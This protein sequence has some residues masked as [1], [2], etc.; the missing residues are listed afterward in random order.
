MVLIT[1][2]SRG[3]GAATAIH[4]ASQAYSICISY[5]T[6]RAMAENLVAELAFLGSHAIAVQADI[7]REEDIL[8]LFKTVDEELGR[9]T[10]L[11]NN[12]GILLRQME[13]EMMTSDR[14]NQIFTTNVTGT[15]ICCR[16]A[17]KRMAI[18]N[19]GN[20]GAI[21]NV[22]SV[23]SRTGAAGEYVDYAASKGAMDTLTKG[24]S[25]EVAR[26]G[27]RV[28]CVRPGLIYT[29]IHSAG[30]EPDRIERVKPKIPMR[31]GGQPGE[32]AA[33]I[34]WLLSDGASYTTG[35]F[36]DLAGGI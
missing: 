7:S 21:V 5:K 11:V 24:L 3:I 6:N 9:L 34:A 32:V 1:G 31:R 36:I 29:D 10:H 14:I 26:E 27:I 30:G 8:R 15:F 25:L 13:V 28:N 18:K 17:I 33:A 23:A 4:L 22:S 19:G 16:E 20:G 12:A 2:A 35:S